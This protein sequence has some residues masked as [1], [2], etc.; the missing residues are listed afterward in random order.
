MKSLEFNQ[1]FN[2]SKDGQFD[3]LVRDIFLPWLTFDYDKKCSKYSEH[4]CHELNFFLFKK[5]REFFEK[6]VLWLL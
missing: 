2:D 5:D 3:D 1:S 4:T 6:V